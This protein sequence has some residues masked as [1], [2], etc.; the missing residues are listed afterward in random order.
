MHAFFFGKPVVKHLL[1]N[2]FLASN[3]FTFFIPGTGGSKQCL[4][5]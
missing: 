2:C 3:L 4:D 1:A 5:G